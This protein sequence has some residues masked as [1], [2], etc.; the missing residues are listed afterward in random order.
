MTTRFARPGPDSLLALAVLLLAV[1]AARAESTEKPTDDRPNVLFIVIDDLN[2]YV[3]CL[4]GHPDARTPH[5]DALAEE[6]ILFTNAHCSSPVCNPSRAALWTG[7]RPTT[8]GITTNPSG[9]FRDHPDYRDI[10]T[11]PLALEGAGYATAGFGKLF[12][13]GHGNRYWPDWQQSRKY[14]YGPRLEPHLHFREGDRLSDWGAPPTN[15]ER[16]RGRPTSDPEAASYDEDIAKRVIHF[17]RD[18]HSGPFF[19]GC[20][21]YRPHTP[22]YARQ[23]W[24]DRFPLE[25]VSLP[26]LR[27]D[28]VDDLPYFENRPRREKDV[29]APGLWN[30]EWVVENGYWKD[31]VRAYLACTAAVD[32][33]VGRVVEALRRSN[34]AAD[35]WVFLFSDHGWHLGEKTYWGKAALW[36]QTTRVPLIVL[37]PGV[38]GG[39]RCDEPVEL[40]HLYPTV[41]DLLDVEPPHDLEGVS[42][43]PLL[44]NADANWNH[45]AITTFSDHHALRTDRWRYIRYVDGSEELYDHDDDPH[46]WTNLAAEGDHPALPDL[47]QRLD[48][49]LTSP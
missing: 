35:T 1:A 14:G 33:Q 2:D 26:T 30:H 17:L 38:E 47:R 12:H 46:E 34:H 22:L 16:R 11:L 27:E 37:G 10:V 3:G 49:I 32:E 28:D 40:L 19:L 4:G 36:E 39:R 31:I 42:L 24:F 29:E 7:L 48:R 45:P 18:R 44:E 6:G 41:L 43:R 9:W 23:E 25:E 5:L 21:F 15:P 8:T 13:L 20:G